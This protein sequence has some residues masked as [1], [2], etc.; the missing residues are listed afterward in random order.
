MEVAVNEP[1]M[2]ELQAIR[3]RVEQVGK[4]SDG[5]VRFGVFR[6]G[7]DGVLAWIPGVGELYSLAA[8]GF[9]LYQGYQAGVSLKTLVTCLGLMLG[10]TTISAVPIAGAVAADLFT[11]HRWSARMVLKEIDR[12]L[13]DLGA[14]VAKPNAWS[15]MWSGRRP[16]EARAA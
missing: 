1:N 10:R 12:K 15:R 16:A 13:A 3:R 7:V 8:G 9:I 4:L 6:L 2:Q 5:L 11:A 14:P